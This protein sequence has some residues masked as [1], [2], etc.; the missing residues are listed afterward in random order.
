MKPDAAGYF[1]R[2]QDRLRAHDFAAAQRA[3]ALVL[4]VE[5]SH[6]GARAMLGAMLAGSDWKKSR[7]LLQGLP[8]EPPLPQVEAAPPPEKGAAYVLASVLRLRDEPRET[9]NKRRALPIGSQ[10]ELVRG[11]PDGW[12]LVRAAK[13]RAAAAVATRRK[14]GLALGPALVVP[15]ALKQELRP[16]WVRAAFLTATPPTRAGL[17]E[18]RAAEAA[19]GRLDAALVWAQRAQEML[20]SRERLGVVIDLALRTRRW[21]VAGSAATVAYGASRPGEHSDVQLAFAWGCTGD[22]RTLELFPAGA[23]LP[24]AACADFADTTPCPACRFEEELEAPEPGSARRAAWDAERAAQRQ[25]DAR[26]FAERKKKFEA[27]RAALARELELGPWVQVRFDPATLPRGQRLFLAAVRPNLNPFEDLPD[28]FADLV[29]VPA[30]KGA[31]EGALHDV[32]VP[33][34]R[35]EGLRYDAFFAPDLAGARQQVDARL[36]AAEGLR[37]EGVATSLARPAD[38]CS[39]GC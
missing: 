25:A 20:P 4:A 8:D 12:V 34:S 30:V 19:A 9:A 5:P 21:R 14:D 23:A 22:P 36:A 17:E 11:G 37:L 18:R 10:V 38:A 39:C 28:A 31:P 16:G 6:P 32:W 7:A 15:A 24:P 29:E 35:D 2:A 1:V 3:L 33:A 26:A 27:R 13:D